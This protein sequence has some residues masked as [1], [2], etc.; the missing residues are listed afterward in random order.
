MCRNKAILF[1][2]AILLW[3]TCSKDI[4]MFVKLIKATITDMKILFKYFSFMNLVRFCDYQTRKNIGKD[5]RI[6]HRYDFDFWRLYLSPL[7][8]QSH[9]YFFSKIVSFPSWGLKSSLSFY[10]SERKASWRYDARLKLLIF[11]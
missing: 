2:E 6:R 3:A 4:K 10:F 5:K 8:L 7:R 11:S 1:F 9:T